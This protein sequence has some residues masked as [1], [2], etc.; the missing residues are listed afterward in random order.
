MATVRKTVT[1]T[2]QQ[3][4]WI[5]AQIEAGEYT[6][7]SEYLRNL[8]RQDQANKTKFLSLKSKLMEGLESGVGTKSI[9][10]IM[11]EVETRMREDGRL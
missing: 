4:K 11:K 2:E 6:N 3:D 1:F 10:E 9:P 7:D 8:V 5:K